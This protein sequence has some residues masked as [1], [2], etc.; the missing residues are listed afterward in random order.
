MVSRAKGGNMD[1]NECMNELVDQIK[2]VGFNALWN[3]RV[4]GGEIHTIYCNAV[5]F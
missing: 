1:V 3:V 5:K 4:T 2:A